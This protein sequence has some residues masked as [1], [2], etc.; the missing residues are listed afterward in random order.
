[1]RWSSS[2]KGQVLREGLLVISRE[3]GES[4][5]SLQ[6]SLFL[7]RAYSCFYG[8]FIGLFV[9][10]C[11]GHFVVYVYVENCSPRV[12]PGMRKMEQSLGQI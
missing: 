7:V 3:H 4:Y 5:F 12:W 9:G 2:R 6:N 1:M 11:I 10:L 8:L